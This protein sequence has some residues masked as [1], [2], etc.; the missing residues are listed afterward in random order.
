MG[1]PHHVVSHVPAA[2]LTALMKYKCHA[3]LVTI[4]IYILQSSRCGTVVAAAAANPLLHTAH[5]GRLRQTA[6][7]HLQYC[8]VFA[9]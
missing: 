6:D 3:M 4:Q 1:A 9:V 2:V 8:P 5:I 7:C